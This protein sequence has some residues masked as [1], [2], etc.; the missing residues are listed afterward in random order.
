MGMCPG[1]KQGRVG[2]VSR[3]DGTPPKEVATYM[4]R[5]GLQLVARVLELALLDLRRH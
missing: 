2:G 1:L 5:E 3:E 4:E